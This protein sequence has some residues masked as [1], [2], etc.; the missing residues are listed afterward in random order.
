MLCAAFLNNSK[1]ASSL[2]IKPNIVIPL[3]GT[4]AAPSGSIRQRV[5]TG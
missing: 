5:T 4:S 1:K 2:G 3:F